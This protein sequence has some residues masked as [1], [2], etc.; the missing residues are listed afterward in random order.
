MIRWLGV[1]AVVSGALMVVFP[2]TGAAALKTR[3]ESYSAFLSQVS[4]GEVRTAV[5][6]PR[7][8]SLRA[9][10][11]RGGRYLVRYPAKDDRKL[12]KRLH[13]KHVHVAF[14]KPRKHHGRHI[15]RRYLVLA[16]GVLALLV[17]LA[18][19]RF[20]AR[21]RRPRTGLRASPPTGI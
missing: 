7:R 3:R 12:V 10:L 13:A 14:G 1:V 17:V 9:R 11:K 16:G 8:T 5:L 20:A 18:A 19:W 4:R 21:R 2:S 15:R 6:T